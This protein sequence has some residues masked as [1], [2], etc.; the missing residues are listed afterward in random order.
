MTKKNSKTKN[1]V[2]KKTKQDKTT[3]MAI[4]LWLQLIIQ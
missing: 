3:R 1:Y 4:L 2:E